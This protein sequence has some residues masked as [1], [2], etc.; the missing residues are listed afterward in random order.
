MFK[1]LGREEFE[2]AERVVGEVALRF[3]KGEPLDIVEALARRLNCY[4]DID[5]AVLKGGVGLS[6]AHRVVTA[7][8]EYTLEGLLQF[9]WE[10]IPLRKWLSLTHSHLPERGARELSQPA[11]G[12]RGEGFLRELER[13]FALDEL[14]AGSSPEPPARGAAA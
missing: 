3:L 10:R 7:V 12:S 13:E 11:R 1:G 6:I 5:L 4:P 14:Q 9:N 8:L 2:E